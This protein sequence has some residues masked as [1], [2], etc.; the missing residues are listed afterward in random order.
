MLQKLRTAVYHAAD[1]NKAKEWYIALTA[2]QPYF[3]EPF[4]VGFNINGFEL[5]IDPDL[6]GIVTGNSSIAYWSVEDIHAAVGKAL[7]IGA[8]ICL[9]ITNV[10]GPIETAAV[11]DPFGNTI[12]FIAGA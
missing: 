4:Y 9:P 5:G 7:S 1:I 6:T 11:T 10:G 12:G 8:V 3:D 2:I